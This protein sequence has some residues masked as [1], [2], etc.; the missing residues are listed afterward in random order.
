MDGYRI[1]A[2]DL[3]EAE[4]DY[5]LSIRSQPINV[6]VIAKR[7]TLRKWLRGTE[8]P[9]YV[10]KSPYEFAN[11]YATIPD[12]LE[13]I[14]DQILNGRGAGCLSRLVHYHKRV[15]RYALQTEKQKDQ[16]KML[17][18]VIAQMAVKYYSV[19]FGEAMWMVPTC[20]IVPYRTQQMD[21]STTD[22]GNL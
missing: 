2:N 8:D 20:Q 13:E 17:M 10:L 3:L 18:Y 22:T 7:R 6:P 9:N 12:K 1:N 14:E 4:L 21:Q 19:D 16:K 15:R 11:D 5:E